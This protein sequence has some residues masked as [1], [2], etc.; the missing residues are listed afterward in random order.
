MIIV[1][2]QSHYIYPWRRLCQILSKQ[3]APL[4][5]FYHILALYK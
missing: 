4:K 5:S 2:Q 3:S 1:I